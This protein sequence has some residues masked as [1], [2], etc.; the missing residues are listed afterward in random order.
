MGVPSWS[1]GNGDITN[2]SRTMTR[3]AH[4]SGFVEGLPSA[5]TNYC[6]GLSILNE[7]RMADSTATNSHAKAEHGY[8]LSRMVKA[9]RTRRRDTR[10]A[11]VR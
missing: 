5:N 7:Y 6:T 2:A 1:I 3:N 10:T 11:R 8:S 4:R 9:N